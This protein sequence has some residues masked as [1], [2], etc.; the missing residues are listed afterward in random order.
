MTTADRS[1]LGGRLFEPRSGH[2][3]FR[4]RWTT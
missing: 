2:W 1:P 4:D 3:Y